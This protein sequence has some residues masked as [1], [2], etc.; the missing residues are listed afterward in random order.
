MKVPSN[1]CEIAQPIEDF[2]RSVRNLKNPDPPPFK[3]KN[4]KR[5]VSAPQCRLGHRF[6]VLEILWNLKK[7]PHLIR[8]HLNQFKMIWFMTF[9]SDLRFGQ[10]KDSGRS[11]AFNFHTFVLICLKVPSPPLNHVCRIQPKDGLFIIPCNVWWGK[12]WLCQDRAWQNSR[13]K[14]LGSLL[15]CGSRSTT[16]DSRKT[17]LSH[18]DWKAN[19]SAEELRCLVAP[20]NWNYCGICGSVW[21][22]FCF[23][24]AEA[25]G[26]IC[27]TVSLSCFTLGEPQYLAVLQWCMFAA[28]LPEKFNDLNLPDATQS[29]F[30]TLRI[31]Q[32][33]LL[34]P[35][36]AVAEISKI[37]NL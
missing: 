35:H 4:G 12:N 6:F 22:I 26:A 20:W 34:E 28:G 24:V 19:G 27:S 1:L 7:T 25:K 30:F 3:N 15:L 2:Y 16:S 10:F 17:H 14:N 21:Q 36:N 32:S 23:H 5:M 31:W 13:R 8:N 37:G 33:I 9:I 29:V 11:F 18:L